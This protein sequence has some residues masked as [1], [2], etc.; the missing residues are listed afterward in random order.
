MGK[1]IG[2]RVSLNPALD[3]LARLSDFLAENHPGKHGGD[4]RESSDLK[5]RLRMRRVETGTRAGEH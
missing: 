2:L 5:R 4:Q 1:G 3:D